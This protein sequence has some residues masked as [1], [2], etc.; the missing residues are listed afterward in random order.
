MEVIVIEKLVLVQKNAYEAKT[1]QV[2]K[3]GQTEASV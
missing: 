1:V 2:V 3:F